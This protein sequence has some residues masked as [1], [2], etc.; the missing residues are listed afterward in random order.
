MEAGLPAS[1]ASALRFGAAA[2]A[3]LP[4]LAGKDLPKGLVAGGLECGVWLALGYIG[5]APRI[6]RQFQ[7]VRPG[8]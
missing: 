6:I 2:A 8:R 7:K 4:L 5:Q 1:A 3:L